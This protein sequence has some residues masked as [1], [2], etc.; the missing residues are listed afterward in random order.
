MNNY[1]ILDLSKYYNNKLIFDNNAYIK[2]RKDGGSNSK[3]LLKAELLPKPTEKII[4][5]HIPYV[6][7][8]TS[9]KK[10]DS[11]SCQEQKVCI[12]HSN[13]KSINI[14]GLG[15]SYDYGDTIKLIFAD[16]GFEDVD[17]YFKNW[18]KN[19]EQ[20]SYD[21]KLSE[22]CKVALETKNYD[23][24]LRSIYYNNCEIKNT[25]KILTSII[26]PYNPYINIFA[27]TLEKL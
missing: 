1:S 23:H 15:R 19:E 27:I 3:G 14:L 12:P 7:P 4:I 9:P 22:Q 5:N 16:N 6:F 13:Y 17:I 24:A 11:I 26:L 8:N 18:T 2:H 25:N 10:D 21:F 20:F